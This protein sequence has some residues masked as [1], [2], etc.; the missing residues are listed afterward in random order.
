L[1]DNPDR[2]IEEALSKALDD[3]LNESYQGRPEEW[4]A[5]A[6]IRA[7]AD[8]S[9]LPMCVN[10]ALEHRRSDRSPGVLEWNRLDA[11][12]RETLIVTIRDLAEGFAA[13]YRIRRVEDS[14][15]KLEDMIIGFSHACDVLQEI[16]ED[17]ILQETG[18][19]RDTNEK[20][21]RRA[22][23]E[24]LYLKRLPWYSEIIKAYEKINPHPQPVIPKAAAADRVHDIGGVAP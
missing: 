21:R 2:E 7:R 11:D 20:L 12:Y 24:F 23:K 15:T 13:T 16:G 5:I 3:L 19:D 8:I 14:P 6:A 18:E 10:R 17:R 9:K 4:K 1:S 22:E